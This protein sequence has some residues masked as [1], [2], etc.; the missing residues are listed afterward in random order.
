MKV[1]MLENN[2][3]YMRFKLSGSDYSTA[4][5]LRRMLINSVDCF[6]IDRVTFYENNS[7]M[8]DEYIAH[9]IGMVP[10]KT[11]KGH[12]EKDEVLFSLEAEGPK[13]V[14]SKDIESKDKEVKVAN[15]DIPI[16][17]LGVNQKIKLDGKAVIGR[18]MKSSKF[19]P[20]V[21]TY[22]QIDDNNYDFYIESF[23][24]MPPAEILKRAVSIIN[25][26]LKEIAKEVKK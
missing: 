5:A 21:A 11:P 18:G 10:I 1:E 6:A 13:T 15:E 23:G 12:D 26:E 4:N 16:I 20:C 25:S 7:V 14:Y 24:Q 22:K 8:F 2:S 17:K 19:Q 3:S 9:R